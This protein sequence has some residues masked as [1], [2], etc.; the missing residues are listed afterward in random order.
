MQFDYRY[1]GDSRVENAA[2]R[3]EMSFAPDLT[4]SATFFRG[5]LRQSLPFREGMSALHEVVDSDLRWK[6]RDR[7]EYMAWLARQEEVDWAEVASQRREKAERLAEVHEELTELRA[8]RARHR[9]PFY[10]AQR[11]YFEY[12]YRRDRDAWIVLDP[13]ITVH[14]DGLFFECFS[15]DESS[16]GRLHVDYEV[17]DRVGEFSCGTTNVDYSSALYDEFQKIRSY[18]TTRFEVD[19]SG[20]EVQTGEDEAYK[21]VKID[22]PESWVRGFLQVSSAATLPAA[23]VTLHPMDVHNICFVLRRKKELFGPRSLRYRL[24][25]GRPVRIVAVSYTHLTLPTM[26]VV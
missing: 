1:S 12:L 6:P 8:R 25:P 3:T 21:E 20:F 16:Y 9:Q 10:A 5:E 7:S 13:V 15:Q 26:C 11:R 2:S 22:L 23:R 14:P 18:K 24:S 17:F 19:P 4:R